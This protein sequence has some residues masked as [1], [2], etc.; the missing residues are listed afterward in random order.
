[1]I[2]SACH[3]TEIGRVKRIIGVVPKVFHKCFHFHENLNNETYITF[4]LNNMF[5]IDNEH[6]NKAEVLKYVLLPA[7]TERGNELFLETP[8]A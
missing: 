6:H 7:L 5:L 3:E 4:L 2:V 1:M 8:F